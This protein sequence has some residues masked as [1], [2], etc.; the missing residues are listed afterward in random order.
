MTSIVIGPGFGRDDSLF[1]TID[2]ALKKAVED[3]N[4]T[5]VGDADFLWFLSDSKFNNLL[6]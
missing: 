2:I 5:F 4:C 1:N 6:A 3:Y